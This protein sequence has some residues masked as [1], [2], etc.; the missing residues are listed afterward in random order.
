ME[1]FASVKLAGIVGT[2]VYTGIGV[3]LLFICWLLLDL[4]TPFSLTKKLE[5]EQNVALAIVVAALFVS[6]AII[7]AAVI[8]SP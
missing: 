5:Q 7:I 6:I 2:V 3:V 4:V 8:V 1:I